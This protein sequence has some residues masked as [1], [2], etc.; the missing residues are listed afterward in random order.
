MFEFFN[1]ILKLW[2]GS[3]RR[4][5]GSLVILFIVIVLCVGV[6]ERWTAGFRLAKLER[7]A[8]ILQTVAQV[9]AADTNA[10]A[11][12]THS[13][14]SQ[15]ADVVGTARAESTG[16]SLITRFLIGLVPWFALG[17][18]FVPSA[19]RKDRSELSA[20]YGAWG[21]G[22]FFSLLAMFLPEGPWPWPHILV[23]PFLSLIVF[24]G[25]VMVIASSRGKKSQDKKSQTTKPEFD[26]SSGADQS[27]SPD[28]PTTGY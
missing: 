17:L 11:V 5:R 25:F 23:Y 20:A 6:Y 16:H 19:L 26:G 27:A 28:E 24:I 14:S 13:I 21:F 1:N 7:S 9:P 8:H 10:L 12:I 15:L 2:Q 22:I 3:S 4:Q 18:L